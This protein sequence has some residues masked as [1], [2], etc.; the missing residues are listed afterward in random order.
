[1]S[2]RGVERVLDML[3]W[4]AASPHGAGLKEIAASLSM[5]KSSALLM[6]QSLSERGYIERQANGHYRLL[7]LPGEISNDGRNYG[8]LITLA[9]P[10]L[11]RAVEATGESGFIAVLEDHTIRYLNK[12]LPKREILYDRDIGQTRPAHQVA[13]GVVL[14][15]AMS[16]AERDACL[17]STLLTKPERETLD[18]ALS[19]AKAQGF[20]LNAKGVVEGAAGAAA[21]IYSEP[22]KA[23]AAINIAGPQSRFVSHSDHI[24]KVVRETAVAISE[25]L[26][27]RHHHRTQ[28]R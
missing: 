13:S 11:A 19:Q 10:Y 23:V 7:R 26:S 2:G 12:V 1:M 15:A 24:C 28:G 3:E 16:D 14:L 18:V 6:L 8:A 25:E 4:F 5:P 27:R 17:T 9:S 21:A 22:G 20:F